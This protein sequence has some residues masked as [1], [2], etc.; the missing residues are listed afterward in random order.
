MV[1]AGNKKPLGNA[2]TVIVKAYNSDKGLRPA[3]GG[4]AE[5]SLWYTSNS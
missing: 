3:W 5:T 4:G 2:A 1:M